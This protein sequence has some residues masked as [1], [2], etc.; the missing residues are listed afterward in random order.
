MVFLYANWIKN[1]AAFL[2]WCRAVSGAG[3]DCPREAQPPA[4]GVCGG[5]A[6]C[7][8]QG[9]AKMLSQKKEVNEDRRAVDLREI[10]LSPIVEAVKLEV[11]RSV[12]RA[13]M[14]EVEVPGALG[15]EG[16]GAA[17]AGDAIN[18]Y[19]EVQRYEKRLIQ[20]ALVQTAGSQKE[21]A[22]LLGMKA[23]TLNTKIRLYH[24][25]VKLQTIVKGPAKP[26]GPKLAG[27]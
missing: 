15:R 1:Y 24:I 18:F 8:N 20:W 26:W 16:D 19:D 27:R 23:T 17:G 11:L 10:D 2:T 9:G 25:P 5:D 6:V 14:F 21:A 4:P 22:R 3:G 12:V 7:L 13:L